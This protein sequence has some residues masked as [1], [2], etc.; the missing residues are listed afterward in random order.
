MISGCNGA[1]KSTLVQALLPHY[2]N[3][4]ALI[5]PD[6][7]AKGLNPLQPDTMRF[8]AGVLALKQ[9]DEYIDAGETFAF[10]TTASGRAYVRRLVAAKARGYKIQ[11]IYIFVENPDIAIARVLN[12]VKEGGHA[13][14]EIDIRR[15]YYRGLKNILNLYVPLAD[16]VSF[17]LNGMSIEQEKTNKKSNLQIFAEIDKLNEQIIYDHVIWDLMHQQRNGDI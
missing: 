17:V 8:K 5:N 2:I 14:P 7:I 6:E 13:V 10:E 3:I 1:G 4:Q 12:R 16:Q 15:R 11:L 9:M